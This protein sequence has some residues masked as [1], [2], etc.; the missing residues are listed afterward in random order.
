MNEYPPHLRPVV[1]ELRRLVRQAAPD[2]SE[3][4]KWNHIVFQQGGDVCYLAP[5][6]DHV[7]FGF[8]R[9]A[10]LADPEG[11]LEGTGKWMR[12]VKVR[13]PGDLRKREYRALVEQAANLPRM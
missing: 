6:R 12:H 10:S 3:I 11:L 4:V 2:A 9:G 8:F 1:D 13:S 7:T 5:A